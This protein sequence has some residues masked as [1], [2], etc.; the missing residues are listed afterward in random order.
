VLRVE[1]NASIV[2]VTERDS[3]HFGGHARSACRRCN[4]M[5]QG[6]VHPDS[7]PDL[8][9]C[10][11]ADVPEGG[12]K[13]PAVP[14]PP[15]GILEREVRRTCHPRDTSRASLLA[16]GRSE[17]ALAAFGSSPGLAGHRDYPLH[18]VADD[19]DVCL[20]VPIFEISR[21]SFAGADTDPEGI[22]DPAMGDGQVAINVCGVDRGGSSNKTDRH[23]TGNCPARARSRA[24]YVRRLL[25]SGGL[26]TPNS[27]RLYARLCDSLNAEWTERRRTL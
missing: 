13:P 11:L 21:P 23:A 16:R 25:D 4:R 1:V 2:L 27:S 14:L 19:Q 24:C 26:C 5:L 18:R 12:V 10:S 3:E 7:H 8:L 22:E 20:P 6:V 9:A 17:R 15:L